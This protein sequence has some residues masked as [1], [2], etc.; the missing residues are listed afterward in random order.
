MQF[1]CDGI[2]FLRKCDLR[3]TAAL[4]LDGLRQAKINL[5]GFILAKCFEASNP[6]LVLAPTTITVLPVKSAVTKGGT[7][8][9]WPCTN[10]KK[11]KC[12]IGLTMDLMIEGR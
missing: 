11:V 2:Q 6:K 9:S 8:P 10:W 4:P 1:E 3:S 5:V 12:P 7:F